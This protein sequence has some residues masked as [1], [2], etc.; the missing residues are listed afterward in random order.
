MKVRCFFCLLVMLWLV[1]FTAHAQVLVL[2]QGYLG[3]GSSWRMAGVTHVLD[4]AGWED[5]GH[6]D[7]QNGKVV[8]YRAGRA[9]Q[10]KT[11]YTLEMPSEAPVLTQA[12]KLAIYMKAIARFHPGESLNIAGFSAGGVVGRTYMVQRRDDEPKVASLVTIATPHLGSHLAELGLK[13]QDTPLTWFTPFMGAGSFNRSDALFHDLRPEESGAFLYWLNR[14]VHPKARYVSI[15]KTGSSLF[16][17]DFIVPVYSQNMNNVIALRG[18]SVV[19][20]TRGGHMLN[21]Q[22]AV[23]LVQL[24]IIGNQ[25]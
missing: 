9:G 3:H 2:L 17:S 6:L 16:D 15:I 5:G 7:I 24:M 18:S 10:D 1:S 23:L 19:L 21:Y 22:D 8:N 13:L 20:R 12:D 11:F 14:Q 4:R 25:I